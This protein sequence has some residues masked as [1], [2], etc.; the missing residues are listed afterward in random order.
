M[1][2]PAFEYTFQD[3]IND[4]SD[5]EWDEW[6]SEAN[7]L[8]LTLDYY[9]QEF[10]GQSWNCHRGG[11][12]GPQCR[13]HYIRSWNTPL[14]ETFLE[15]SFQNVRSSKRT[16]EFHKALLNEVLNTNPDWAEYDW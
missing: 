3:F 16:D 4:A 2:V 12:K 14:M 5:A 8:E 9:I 6:E 1:C 15:T 10:V 13:L 7:R 11:C